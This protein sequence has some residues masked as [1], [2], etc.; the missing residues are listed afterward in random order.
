MPDF[1]YTAR[2]MQ[3]NKVNG[4]VAAPNQR[5]A[6]ALLSGQALFPLEVKTQQQAKSLWAGRRVGGNLMAVTYVQLASLLRSG[7]PLLRSLSLLRDQASN[8]KLKETLADVVS[9]VEDG[10]SLG[11]AM[12]RHPRVFHDIAVNMARAGTEGG[13]LAVRS[14]PWPIRCFSR[15][16]V[17][18][19][20][21]SC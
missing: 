3:G 10:E 1:Q 12:S 11:D 7:V 6:L 15:W 21:V 17:R 4:V 8:S 9:R 16:S 20:L 18:W 13:F 19:W 14:V 2:D 5:D